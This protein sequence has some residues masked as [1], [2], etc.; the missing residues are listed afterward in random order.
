MVIHISVLAGAIDTDTQILVIHTANGN[1]L[2]ER[3]SAAHIH[4]WNRT[5]QVADMVGLLQLH[6][7]LIQIDRGSH[8]LC[9][10]YA[11][12]LQRW[13]IFFDVGGLSLLGVSRWS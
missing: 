7:R 6:G 5:Q 8:Y 4:T 9:S 12:L 2:V 13:K 1:A 11:S 3:V 10:P